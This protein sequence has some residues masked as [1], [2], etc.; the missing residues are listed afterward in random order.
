MLF[1]YWRISHLSNVL[2]DLFELL[3]SMNYFEIRSHILHS[4][5]ALFLISKN[6][7][8]KLIKSDFLFYRVESHCKNWLP[9]VSME[10]LELSQIFARRKVRSPYIRSYGFLS[11][12]TIVGR[13]CGLLERKHRVQSWYTSKRDSVPI[14]PRYPP[15]ISFCY[16]AERKEDSKT[17]PAS[18]RARIS[19]ASFRE[20]QLQGTLQGAAKREQMLNFH[21]KLHQAVTRRHSE[22]SP[23]FSL[24]SKRKLQV[25]T[26]FAKS[27]SAPL[28]NKSV[29]VN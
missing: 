17:N 26:V 8:Q 16:L 1:T 4:I 23:S 20:L 18:F 11:K 12:V 25:S 7:I 13:S 10:I 24:H 2:S 21:E 5:Y 22:H 14:S 15:S 29:F 27:K 3:K 19:R 28:I 6:T 9:R